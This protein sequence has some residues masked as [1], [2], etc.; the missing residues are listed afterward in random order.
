MPYSR[1]YNLEGFIEILESW[2]LSDVL[3]P[4]LLIFTILFAVLQKT[5]ILG[6]QKKRFNAI[7]ALIIALLVVIPHVL[8][9]YPPGSDIVVIMNQSLPQIAIIVVAVVMVLLLI[10]LF[11]GEAKWMGSSLSGWIA[12][13]AFLIVIYIFGGAAGWWGGYDWFERVVG[14]DVIAIIVMLLMFAIIIWFVTKGEGTG[15][16]AESGLIKIGKGFQELFGGR[17]K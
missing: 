17:G 2:G 9:L 16:K 5:R 10:G 13:I 3:L 7:V 1:A 4:L 8:G 11:G 12:I 6:E 15:E 14:S